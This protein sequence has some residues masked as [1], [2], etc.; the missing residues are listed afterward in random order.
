MACLTTEPPPSRRWIAIALSAL[1]LVALGATV[2]VVRWWPRDEPA[3]AARARLAGD[4]HRAGRRRRRRT[5]RRSVGSRPLLGSVRRRRRRADGTIFV[6]DAGD[7][8]AIRRISPDGAVST[9]AGGDARLRRW[10]GRRRALQHAVRPRDRSAG[11]ALRRRHRQQR[12]SAHHARRP[13]SRRS[14]ATAPPGSPTAPATQARFNGP[15][16]VAVDAS[17]RV[18][19]A[20]TYNDRIRAIAPDGTVDDA[21]RRR[22]PG[23][24]DRPGA[25]GALRYAVR[26]RRRCVRQHS[27][28]RHRQRRRSA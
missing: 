23:L 20:D 2:F 4:G 21:R 9:L 12:D 10:H 27:R 22:E 17:G 6:A 26:R 7:A 16:G 19:V 15:I 1:A 18:I 13:S 11:R 5:P 24:L 3:P 8:N 25:R 28:R 14:P